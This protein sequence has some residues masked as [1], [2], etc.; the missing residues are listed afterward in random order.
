M[1][2]AN[3]SQ[4]LRAEKSARNT[5]TR[6]RGSSFDR[7]AQATQLILSQN[8]PDARGEQG[9]ECLAPGQPWSAARPATSHHFLFTFAPNLTS[10]G[11]RM[12]RHDR[13]R[14]NEGANKGLSGSDSA[15]GL[16]S[17]L[18][19]GQRSQRWPAMI[20]ECLVLWPA[21]IPK[22]SKTVA[23][24]NPRNCRILAGQPLAGL[25]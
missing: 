1:S 5:D 20:L 25:F 15:L 21:R 16:S 18:I 7:A 22:I 3:H 11:A 6:A 23:G 24:W 19:C 14:F 4:L 13:R 10:D 12:T 2:F 8:S 9:P 17:T